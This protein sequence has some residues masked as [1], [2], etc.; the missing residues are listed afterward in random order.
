MQ[1]RRMRPRTHSH[2][3]DDPFS[4]Q[5]TTAREVGSHNAIHTEN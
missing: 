1:W 3:L 4:L 2:E 5:Q